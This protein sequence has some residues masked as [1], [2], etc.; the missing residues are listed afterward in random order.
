MTRAPRSTPTGNGRLRAGLPEP[1]RP[2]AV[3]A[4]THGRRALVLSGGGNLG[5]IQVGILRAVYAKGFRP[6]L[7]VG[8]SIGALNGAV[9]AFYPDDEGL[10]R[11]VRIWSNLRHDLSFAYNPLHLLRNAAFKRYCLVDSGFLRRIL[12]EHLPE[13]DFAAAEVPLYVVATNLTQGTKHVFV[14][15]R[16][17]DAVLASAAVPGLLCPID[18]GGQ[19]YVDGAVVA[20]LDLETAVDAGADQVLAIDLSGLWNFE[21]SQ[22]FLGILARSLDLMVRESTTKEIDRLQGRARITVLR[23]NASHIWPADFSHASELIAAGEEIECQMA[24]CCFR[25]DGSLVPGIIDELE[26]RLETWWK[27]AA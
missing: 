18:I 6:D 25:S 4:T 12:E 10:A 11:L 22:S 8:T 14:S 20:N 26:V 17:S 23:V 19:V 7:I 2:R 1:S 5:A 13:D 24:R 15:G 27:G 3:R 21:P 9:L 16:V